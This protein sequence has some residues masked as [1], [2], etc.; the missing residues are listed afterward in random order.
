LS[1][2]GIRFYR[3]LPNGKKQFFV[4]IAVHSLKC[5]QMRQL[6]FKVSVLAHL[7]PDDPNEDVK[8]STERLE[9]SEAEFMHRF[10]TLHPRGLNLNLTGQQLRH[11]EDLK[12]LGKVVV[13]NKIFSRGEAFLDESMLKTFFE[14]FGATIQVSVAMFLMP[15]FV[16][17]VEFVDSEGAEKCLEASPHI[18]DGKTLELSK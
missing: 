6:D 5:K 2:D 9:R 7:P 16:G 18:V 17:S 12:R 13:S 15:P 1:G 14:K 11:I 8:K 3:Y 10:K 4:G